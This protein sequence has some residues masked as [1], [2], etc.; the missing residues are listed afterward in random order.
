MFRIELVRY[1]WDDNDWSL[2]PVGLGGHDED[3]ATSHIGIAIREIVVQSGGRRRAPCAVHIY[4]PAASW[5]QMLPELLR[6]VG[7]RGGGV[8]HMVMEE[9]KNRT[10]LLR[11]LTMSDDALIAAGVEGVGGE[12]VQLRCPANSLPDMGGGA[13]VATVV[14]YPAAEGIVW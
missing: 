8:L 11:A 2:L 9:G 14:T 5:V 3:A 10:Y 13:P 7:L 6:P 1:E 12:G 4:A